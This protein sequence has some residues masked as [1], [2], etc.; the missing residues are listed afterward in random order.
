[1]AE[2]TETITPEV[3]EV[4]AQKSKTVGDE[5]M[6]APREVEVNV[7][8][9]KVEAMRVQPREPDAAYVPVHETHVTIDTVITDPSSPLAVQIPDAGRGTMALPIT[10]LN[11]G[12]V[13]AVFA[14]A[15]KEAAEKDAPPKPAKSA[16]K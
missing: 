11:D 15:S 1:M 3:P 7:N 5:N 9:D 6:P 16:T 14:K 13:E 2:T 12:G 4:S 8:K 10:G